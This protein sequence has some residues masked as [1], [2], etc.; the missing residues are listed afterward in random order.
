MG[1]FHADRVGAGREPFQ[2]PRSPM[3]TYALDKQGETLIFLTDPEP[4]APRSELE[5]LM[6]PGANGPPPHCHV[7]QTETF[8]VVSG[9]VRVTLDGAEH[10][11]GPGDSVVVPSGGVHTFRN[12]LEDAPLTFRVTMEPALRFQWV[13]SEMAKAAIRG[14]GSWDDLSLLE[15]GWIMHQVR[16]EYYAI[17]ALPRPL[18]HALTGVLAALA[19][20]TGRH[21]QI[22]APPI[23][24]ATRR[25]QPA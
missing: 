5:V 16:G 21:C 10:R 13:L 6:A 9:R 25:R 3:H 15:V 18:H 2:F 23:R 1:E 4:E 7:G 8:E 19:R 14:G 24:P 12:D 17:P 22:E 11:L 20:L